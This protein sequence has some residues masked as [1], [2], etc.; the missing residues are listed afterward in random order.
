[1]PIET[2]GPGEIIGEM[3]ALNAL[4][5]EG[6]PRPKIYPRSATVRAKTDVIAFEMLPHIL[7]NILYRDSAFRKK[8]DDN[9]TRRALDSHLRAVPLF[10]GNQ[11]LIDLVRDRTELVNFE[12]GDVICREGDIAD[13]F[14]L[15]R[16]GFVKVSQ[17]FPGGELVLNYLSRGS[18]LGEIG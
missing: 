15:I 11:K 16:M 8:L 18:Y 7:N 4:V 5:Q 14:Y 3:A 13:A 17:K 10:G 9:Y 2:V 6:R 12:P 1:N